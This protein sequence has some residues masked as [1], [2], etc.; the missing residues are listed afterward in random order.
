MEGSMDDSE[1]D[2]HRVQWSFVGSFNWYMK[3]H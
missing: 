2:T 1:H 3:N